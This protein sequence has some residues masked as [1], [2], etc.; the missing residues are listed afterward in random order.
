M[1]RGNVL[2]VGDMCVSFLPIKLLSFVIRDFCMK[3]QSDR[4]LMIDNCH[5]RVVQKTE[6]T[7]D[8]AS[9]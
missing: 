9:L 5:D 2:Y 4:S 3:T 1:C 6:T 8:R 7:L